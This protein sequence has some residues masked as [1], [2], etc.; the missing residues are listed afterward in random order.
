M[1]GCWHLAA[2]PFGD[3]THEESMRSLQLFIDEVMPAVHS[4]GSSSASAP[5]TAI[6]YFTRPRSGCN[7]QN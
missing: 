2:L 4:V 7:T 5:E 6:P 3:M 1:G